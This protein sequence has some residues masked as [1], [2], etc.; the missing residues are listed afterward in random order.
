MKIVKSSSKKNWVLFTTN[1]NFMIPVEDADES[2]VEAGA[3]MAKAMKEGKWASTGLTDKD[4]VEY[5][6]LPREGEEIAEA[7][8]TAIKKVKKMSYTTQTAEREEWKFELEEA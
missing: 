3:R 2:A 6:S 8:A 4:E 1:G 7:D 5:Y